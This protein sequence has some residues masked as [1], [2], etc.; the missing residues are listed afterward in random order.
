MKATLAASA[1]FVICAFLVF[2]PHHRRVQSDFRSCTLGQIYAEIFSSAYSG[3]VNGIHPDLPLRGV[4]WIILFTAASL[5]AV[6]F[7]ALFI[8]LTQW[9]PS[10]ST[11][12]G[13]YVTAGVLAVVGAFANFLA[14][15]ISHLD[16]GFGASHSLKN[17][18]AFLWIIPAFQAFF[19]FT[20]IAAGWSDRFGG[21]LNNLL[22]QGSNISLAA[23]TT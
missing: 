18:T 19:G 14:M 15:L 6:L 5:L 9:R 12:A 22:K 13:I 10:P 2:A 16:I 1:L 3:L 7:P 8:G 4:V 23:V 11:H 21:W 20:S 17:E